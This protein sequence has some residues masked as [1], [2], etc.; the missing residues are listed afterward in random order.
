MI[1]SNIFA[2]M[3]SVSVFSFTPLS[4]KGNVDKPRMKQGFSS[5]LNFRNT[6]LLSQGNKSAAI[7]VPLCKK[8]LASAVQAED[9]HFSLNNR[10]QMEIIM[11]SQADRDMMECHHSEKASQ[12]HRIFLLSY[13]DNSPA[14]DECIKSR[15]G[16]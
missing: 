4:S 8:T 12:S 6:Q 7:E 1:S 15:W 14:Q 11:K 2:F 5:S 9:C 3:V 13:R 10:K 16:P